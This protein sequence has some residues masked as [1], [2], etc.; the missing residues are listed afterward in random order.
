MGVLLNSLSP[1]R[2]LLLILICFILMTIRCAQLEMECLKVL[3]E[4]FFRPMGNV[5]WENIEVA[6]YHKKIKGA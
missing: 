2:M 1:V 4:R 6:N 5:H 3:Q